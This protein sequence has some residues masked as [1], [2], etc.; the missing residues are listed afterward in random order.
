MNFS[1]IKRICDFIGE[2]TSGKARDKFG[3]TCFVRCMENVVVDQRV[4]TEEC[5]L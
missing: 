4:V 2:D 1:L 3:D 5:H